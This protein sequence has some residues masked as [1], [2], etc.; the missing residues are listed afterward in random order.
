MITKHLGTSFKSAPTA[1]LA[2]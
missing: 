2:K 1:L